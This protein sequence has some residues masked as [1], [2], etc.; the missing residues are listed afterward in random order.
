VGSE[1]VRRRLVVHGHVQGVFFRDSTGKRARREGVSGWARNRE[2]GA[3]EI[4]LEGPEPAV[5][6]VAAFCQVGPPRAFVRDFEIRSEEPEGLTG[7]EIR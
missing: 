3:V 1:I 4:V 6:S 5:A 2:D 7:F